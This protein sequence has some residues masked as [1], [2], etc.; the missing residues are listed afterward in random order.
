MRR[1][2][3]EIGEGQWGAAV[4]VDGGEHLVE[5]SAPGFRAW[6]TKVSVG[7]ESATASVAVPPLV[8]EPVK[9]PPEP[10][11]SAAGQPG[12][13]WGPQRLAG[14]GVGLAGVA[15]LVAGGVAG[16]V[17]SAKNGTTKHEC[18]PAQ[19]NVCTAAGVADR[20]NAFKLANASTGLL[21]GGAMAAA[22]GVTLL[23][24]PPSGASAKTGGV[25]RIEASPLAG[26]GTAG[27]LLRG[28]W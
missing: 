5:V 16:G 11:P 23:V 20:A 10:S 26:A 8:P 14:L 28:E 22:A 4:P 15:A 3:S 27:L 13:V 12:F 6:T 7:S 1:D 17:A 9:I 19:P 21:I 25:K 2:G 24:V 18:L